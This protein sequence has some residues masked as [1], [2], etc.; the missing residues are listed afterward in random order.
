MTEIYLAS[1]NAHKVEE[2][3]T[4]LAASGLRVKVHSAKVLGGMPEVDEN[5]DTF[6][7]NAKLK[8]Q[9]LLPMAPVGSFVLADDSGLAVNALGGAPGIYSARYAERVA[10]SGTN[11]HYEKLSQQAYA[12]PWEALSTDEKNNVTLLAELV[13]IDSDRRTAEFVCVFS[14]LGTDGTC[15]TFAGVCLGSIVEEPRGDTGFGYDP[16]FVPVGFEQTFAELGAEVKNRLSHRSKAVQA[17]ATWLQARS[18]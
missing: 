2:I 10:P 16:Y 15:E 3:S 5:G 6:A 18:A 9:A 17:L 12:R 8:A 1:G 7:A 11:R 4:M 14:L 13:G